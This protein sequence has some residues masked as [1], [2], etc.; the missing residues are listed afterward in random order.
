M[1]R[2]MHE[3][4]RVRS[5][6]AQATGRASAPAMLKISIKPS[7]RLALVLCA[8]HAAAAGAV[9]IVE[10]PIWLKIVLVLIIGA[11]CGVYLYG[12]ALLLSSTAV[13]GLEISDDGVLS[14]QMRCGEWCTGRLLG[15]SF[16]SP[17]LTVLNIGIEGKFFARHVVILPDCVDAEDFRRLRVRLRWGG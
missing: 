17:H 11:S 6:V 13:V 16:V 4:G 2:V 14:F 10:F 5:G 1:P 15:S 12:T 8:A 3:A 9:L 7:R